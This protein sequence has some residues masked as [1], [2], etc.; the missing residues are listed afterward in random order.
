MHYSKWNGRNNFWVDSF[1]HLGD[2]N[3]INGLRFETAYSLDSAENN[4]LLISEFKDGEETG[5]EIGISKKRIWYIQNKLGE[6]FGFYSI[7]FYKNGNIESISYSN[8]DTNKYVKYTFDSSGRI[9]T[10]GNFDLKYFNNIFYMNK[11]ILDIKSLFKRY[12]LET[13]NYNISD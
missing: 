2:T 7:Y 9:L 8:K 12:G 13:S 6:D 11:N 1:Q 10:Y 5:L 4:I 3:Q